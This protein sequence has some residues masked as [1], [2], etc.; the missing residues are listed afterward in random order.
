[1]TAVCWGVRPFTEKN[2]YATKIAL[3][4]SIVLFCSRKTAAKKKRESRRFLA[5]NTFF[6]LSRQKN[7]EIPTQ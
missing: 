2:V 3:M 7:N 1:M 6:S 5:L 4:K